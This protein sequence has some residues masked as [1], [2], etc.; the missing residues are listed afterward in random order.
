VSPGTFAAF[1]KF[2]L[3]TSNSPNIEVVQ[4]DEGHN[5]HVEWHLRFGVEM[6]AKAW[7]MPLG[8]IHRRSEIC[9]LSIQFVQKW[10]RKMLYALYKSCRGMQ[11]Q[12]L[13]YS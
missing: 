7:S 13:S 5:F 3:N 1:S 8:T 2:H 4:F 9:K 11:D 12:Q 6:R 10:L